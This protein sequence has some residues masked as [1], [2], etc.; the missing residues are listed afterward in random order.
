MEHRKSKSTILQMK[1]NNLLWQHLL[2]IGGY[3]PFPQKE[4]SVYAPSTVRTT[5]MFILETLTNTR[6]QSRIQ[7][8][9]FGI[10]VQIEPIQDA[11]LLTMGNFS[12]VVTT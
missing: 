4:G 9:I 1:T 7:V 12:G 5:I 3:S 2:V 11:I 6:S 8:R 10:A